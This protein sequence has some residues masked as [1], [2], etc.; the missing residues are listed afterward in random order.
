MKG[1]LSTM[2]I[3]SMF[4]F[5]AC[6]TQQLAPGVENTTDIPVTHLQTGVVYA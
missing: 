1:L 3:S 4:L 2:L 5:N 6:D